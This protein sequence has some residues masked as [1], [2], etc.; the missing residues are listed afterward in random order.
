MRSNNIGIDIDNRTDNQ[1]WFSVEGYE[2]DM[3]KIQCDS[4]RTN[5]IGRLLQSVPKYI[6]GKRTVVERALCG[7]IRIGISAL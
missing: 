2:K 4:K 6:V 1:G 7:R 5:V 3:W